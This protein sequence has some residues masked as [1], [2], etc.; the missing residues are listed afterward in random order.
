MKQISKHRDSGM[1]MRGGWEPDRILRRE[2]KG[3]TAVGLL[4]FVGDLFPDS[5][6]GDLKKWLK[7]GH[8]AVD[9]SVTTAFDAPVAPGSVVELNT[10]RPFVVFRHP[11]IKLVYE[12]DDIIVI[13]KGYGLLSV[14]T[15]SSKKTSVETAYSILR[16][17]VKSKHP[18]NK[19]FIVH[20]LDRDTSGLMVFAKTIESK[21]AL[22]HNWNNMV[23]ERKYVALL[24]GELDKDSGEVRSHL[25]E[26]VQHE[27][28][29]TDDPS[30]GKLAV[31]RYK[32]RRKG[33]GHTLAEFSLDTGRKNQIR[34]HARD[35]GCPITGDKRYGNGSGPLHRLA[36][37]AETL[38]F[39]HPVSRKDMNFTSPV[40]SQFYR[41]V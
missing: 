27:V 22:Q 36:L 15:D 23:L 34:V 32:V 11:R 38:R 40:P 14:G 1:R 41:Y 19:I 35:L 8:L 17:Y 7:F 3:D 30:E 5:K 4:T 6:R 9:G 33:K 39:A 26:T 24:D 28:Y 20:R 29:S 37:H 16:E 13:D 18:S 2:N 12:D 21:E 31:T 10:T 25:A